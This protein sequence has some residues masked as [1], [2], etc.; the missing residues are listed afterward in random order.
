MKKGAPP[1]P[2]LPRE[3]ADAEH[4][5]QLPG[6]RDDVRV[7]RRELPL[8]L[9]SGHGRIPQRRVGALARGGHSRRPRGV[10]HDEGGRLL[11]RGRGVA[12]DPSIE[13]H[14]GKI[15]SVAFIIII[16]ELSRVQRSGT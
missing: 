7:Q 11:R 8:P 3:R 5:G 15:I 12:Q 6:L 4:G 14:R 13:Y 2:T 10:H 16:L 9:H 1:R